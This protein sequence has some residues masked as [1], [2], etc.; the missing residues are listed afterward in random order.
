MS[1][2]PGTGGVAADG[3]IDLSQPLVL[4][5]KQIER[6]TSQSV[7]DLEGFVDEIMD[8]VL[9]MPP[10]ERFEDSASVVEDCIE[11]EF[12]S[13]DV[14]A[15][16]LGPDAEVFAQ[17]LDDLLDYLLDQLV[18]RSLEASGEERVPCLVL[19]GTV[20]YLQGLFEVL[21]EEPSNREQTMHVLSS[22]V[23]LY[24]RVYRELKRESDG[25]AG[26]WAAVARDTL[27][28]EGVFHQ[29]SDDDRSEQLT[30]V[31]DLRDRAAIG[32]VGQYGAAVVYDR[33]E[34]SLS[35]GA[36]LA[37]TTQDEFVE[38]VRELGIRP[39]FGPESPEDLYSDPDL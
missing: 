22:L 34:I 3:S 35:R 13:V 24:A 17:F 20:D 1:G 2:G 10:G 37:A 26:N 18:D 25:E 21:L 6:E 16:S 23:A 33:S 36:E 11:E 7:D 14:F 4:V 12:G 9:S 29:L 31:D 30:D 38:Y 15:A 5:L 28:S 32:R 19:V 27:R 39:R 8:R